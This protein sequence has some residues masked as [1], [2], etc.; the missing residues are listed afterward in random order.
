MGKIKVFFFIF[1]FL[2]AFTLPL[3]AEEAPSFDLEQIIITAS[4]LEQQQSEG[5]IV[6]TKV[7]K[8]GKAT[9]VGDLLSDLT[10]INMNRRAAV[11]DTKDTIKLRGFDSSRFLVV[12]DDRPVNAAGVVGGYY[13][14]WST[15]PLDNVEKV[16]VIRGPKSAVYGNTLGG[17]IKITTKKGTKEPITRVQTMFGSNNLQ[18]YLLEH[19][20]SAGKLSYIL[21]V[22]KNK[23]DGY[24]RNNFFDGKDCS[25]KTTYTLDN[26][27]EL[28][29]GFQSDEAKRGYIVANSDS[30]KGPISD[31]EII[32]PG[33][34][35]SLFKPNDGAYCD[36]TKNYY[37]IT[38]KQTTQDGFWQVQYFRNQEDRKEYNYDANGNLVLDRKVASD[39]S[40]GWSAKQEKKIG[41]HKL[42]YGVEEKD[43]GYGDM[44]YN[45]AK[46]G[47]VLIMDNKNMGGP[48]VGPSYSTL[49]GTVADPGP[50]QKLKTQSLYLQDEYQVNSKLSYLLGL[51]YDKYEGR[52]DYGT[53][54]PT[55]PP[56]DGNGLSPKFEVNYQFNSETAGYFSLSRAYRVPTMPEYYWW[57]KGNGSGYSTGKPLKAEAGT[58]YEIGLKKKLGDKTD[59]R[60]AAYYNDVDNYIY[61]N[62]SYTTGMNRQVYNIDKVKIYGLE[63]DGQHKI[64]D[65]LTA[66]ANYTYEKTERPYDDITIGSAGA[67]N[68]LDYHPRNKANIGLRYQTKD[69]T[70]IALSARCVSSQ[71]AIYMPSGT[72]SP[73]LKTL[74]GYTVANLS[75][76]HPLGED[77]E[78][79]VYVDNLFDKQYSEVYGY[80]MQGTT[81]GI[82]Y[83][84]KF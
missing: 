79:S 44:W 69:K 50:T 36:K 20:G 45:Y 6:S 49:G 16:E 63:L 54:D 40:W 9:N 67:L 18:S 47:S 46:D 21:T 14:D 53:N 65:N 17:V 41:I 68:E 1:I 10:G 57:Y 28:T 43:F 71:K 82:A 77:K 8:P 39:R 74:G 78:M 72:V 80:P 23:T 30:S 76:T 70:Q 25:L 32:A 75:V 24:L 62:I 55:L 29:L 61:N 34:G 48:L 38:Y 2:F 7:V 13:V 59:Y 84:Q 12:V 60:V 66:F 3:A 15:F 51:R 31:G 5:T 4:P 58:A 11:G 22:G 37:D 19:S 64:N 33:S 81:Y 73:T 42:T 56:I 27:G 83:K 52:H 26:Q 35:A